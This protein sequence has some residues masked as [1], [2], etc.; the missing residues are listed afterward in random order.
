MNVLTSADLSADGAPLLRTGAG[1]EEEFLLAS[2]SN[3]EI[4]AAASDAGEDDDG[5]AQ[6]LPHSGTAGALFVTT[7]RVV[8]LGAPVGV[9]VGYAWEM[10]SVTLHAIS[11]DPAAFPSPCL[12]CQMSSP[13]VSEVRF[14]PADDKTLQEVFDAF[15]KSAEMNPDDDDEDD[16]DGWICDE[17]EVAD[18]ARAA[19]LA[20]HFDSMLQVS[21]GLENGATEAGQFEDADEDSLL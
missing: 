14:V 1:D 10:S 18:G 5:E 20:A 17:D 3:V 9:H 6:T 19:Q 21:P 12:Y 13:D 15:C 11:R 8:W 16:D 2:F 4:H 7:S